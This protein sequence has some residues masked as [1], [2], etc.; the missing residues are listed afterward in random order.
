MLMMSMTTCRGRGIWWVWHVSSMA[1]GW[2]MM[3][4]LIMVIM[5]MKIKI[6]ISESSIIMIVIMVDLLITMVI[7]R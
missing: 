6:L 3:M 4:E 1:H 5:E 7:V 2:L